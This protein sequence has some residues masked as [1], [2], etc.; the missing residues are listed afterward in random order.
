MVAENNALLK[1]I[2]LCQ[3]EGGN[4][5]GGAEGI[6]STPR[7]RPKSDKP[8]PK[9]TPPSVTRRIGRC[10]QM[11]LLS[12]PLVRLKGEFRFTAAECYTT[13]PIQDALELATA[14]FASWGAE[15]AGLLTTY[16]PTKGSKGV[17]TYTLFLILSVFTPCFGSG[18]V[19]FS[20]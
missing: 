2:K 10:I 4:V 12:N 5:R 11:K 19:T 14:T 13:D 15:G 7:K 6:D 3:E 1:A 8:K 20:L 17:C 9:I 18:Q 16:V